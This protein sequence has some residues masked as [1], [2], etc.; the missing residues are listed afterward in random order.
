MASERP[1]YG[2]RRPMPTFLAQLV[3]TRQRAPQTRA[4]RRVAP[5]EA[6]AAYGTACNAVLPT[7]MP[8]SVLR[9]SV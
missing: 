9:R 3:A 5:A 8:G 2:A 1:S 6:V 7:E 4:G